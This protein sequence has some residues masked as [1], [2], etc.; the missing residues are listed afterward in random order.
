MGRGDGGCIDVR[1]KGQGLVDGSG[2]GG[3]M[4]CEKGGG[5]GNGRWKREGS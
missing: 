1:R 5:V 4:V 3:G 2:K